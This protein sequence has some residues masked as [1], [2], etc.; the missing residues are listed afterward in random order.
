MESRSRSEFGAAFCFSIHWENVNSVSPASI[1]A[2]KPPY[3]TAAPPA[4]AATIILI[5][6]SKNFPPKLRGRYRMGICRAGAATPL[7]AMGTEICRAGTVDEGDVGSRVATSLRIPPTVDWAMRM[8]GR[9]ASCLSH[10][11]PKIREKCLTSHAPIRRGAEVS[12]MVPS[13]PLEGHSQ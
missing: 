4:S 12:P 10:S 9:K 2:R 8:N 5:P 3:S 7:S 6:P 1:G 13:Q 11:S